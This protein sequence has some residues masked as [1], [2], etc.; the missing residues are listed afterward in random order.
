[1]SLTKVSAMDRDGADRPTLEITP[2]MA[3][4]GADAIDGG[5]DIDGEQNYPSRAEWASDI[6]RAMW[7]AKAKDGPA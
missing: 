7:A 6:F 4:A 1:M 2:S 5:F 3:A